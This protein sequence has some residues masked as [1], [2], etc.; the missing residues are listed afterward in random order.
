MRIITY[1]AEATGITWFA[2]RN[3]RFITPW[4][5]SLIMAVVSWIT[6]DVDEVM[7]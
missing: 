2:I 1:R 3:K 5:M 6:S 4:C 7:K